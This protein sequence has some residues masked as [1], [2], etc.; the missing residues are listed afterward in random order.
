MSA[1]QVHDVPIGLQATG[2]R[3]GSDSLGEV[4]APADHY[5][6][7]MAGAEDD[8]E[9][10]AFRPVVPPASPT[11]PWTTDWLSGTP[12]CHAASPRTSTTGSSDPRASP[13]P[14]RPA[15]TAAADR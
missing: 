4:E 6:V 8:S 7:S 12:P 14:G 10:N 13:G 9:L 15:R 1:P 2:T 3:T 11:T 5:W